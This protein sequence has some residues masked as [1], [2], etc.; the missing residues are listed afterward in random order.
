[1]KLRFRE[2]RLERAARVVA[3]FARRGR[4]ALR[5]E[6]ELMVAD[7]GSRVSKQVVRLDDDGA[8][9]IPLADPANTSF[10]IAEPAFE[11]DAIAEAAKD[12]EGP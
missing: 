5:P 10:A 3:R 4:L 8:I 6:V 2:A 1:M 11:P 9:A 12:A 7:R